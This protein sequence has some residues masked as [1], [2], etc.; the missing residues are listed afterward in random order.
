[1]PG[2]ERSIVEPYE[3]SPIG[4][5]CYRSRVRML[6]GTSGNRG[7]S[8]VAVV[9]ALGLVVA[10]LGLVVV[11]VVVASSGTHAH[12]PSGRV[13]VGGCEHS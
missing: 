13:E 10:G 8:V 7:A 12:E 6:H 5:L 3:P 9:V 2:P 4:G 1:M 11:E